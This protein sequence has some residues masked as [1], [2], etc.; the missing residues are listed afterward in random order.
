MQEEERLKQ[1]KI[2]SAHLAGTSKDK[3]KKR[4]KNKEGVEVPYQKKQHKE[5]KVDGCFFCGAAGHKK[6]QCTNYNALRAKKGT[7]LNLVCS[8]VNLTSVPKRT[9][10]I[11]FGATTHINVSMQGCLSCRKPNDGERYIFIGDGKKVEVEAIGIFRLLIK[12]GS[13]LDLNETFVVPSF[14]WNLVSIY[15]LDKFGYSC[16]FGNNKFRLFQNSNLVGT[17]S[18]SYVDN[19]YMLDIV[20]SY[21]ETLQLS[22][23]GVKRKLTNENSSSLLHKRLGHISK[24]RIERLVSNGI[25]DSLDFANFEI[26]TNYIKGKQT[27][28][29]RFGAN[30]VTDVLE[31]IHTDICGSF[32]TFSWNDKQYFITFIDYFSRYSYLYL[33]HEKSQ[34]LEVF[35]SFKVEVENQLKKRIK[36]VRSDR[37]REYYGKYDGSGEQHSEPFSKFL[38]ECGIVPQYTMSG[39]PSM[40]G[41]AER[42][43]IMI[44]DM[45]RSMISHSNLPKSLWGEALKTVVYILNRV[46][47]KATAKT[48]YELW[49]CKKPSLKHLHIWGC[50]AEAR[51]YRPHEKKLDSRMVSCY[52]I[53]Y[54]K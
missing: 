54:S 38:E 49:T 14:R 29:R 42:R 39:S 40:N 43:N 20:A 52:F 37:G 47:T 3:G 18:L 45:V 2:E 28:T 26:C 6:K 16:S 11:D 46:P 15:V 22:T 17:G 53:R 21:H 41:V 50:L 44:K 10:W 32:P 24:R 25:L 27:N 7:L 33:I 8:E 30:K 48:P 1:E 36:N 31:L 34:S 9:W 23:R 35:K 13:Y 4:K 19:L 51:P 12:S 5:K